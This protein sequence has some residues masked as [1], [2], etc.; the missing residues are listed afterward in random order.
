MSPA[1]QIVLAEQDI[2]VIPERGDRL[3][4]DQARRAREGP[5]RAL[6]QWASPDHS[7]SMAVRIFGMSYMGKLAVFICEGALG[8]R[9]ALALKS[10]APAI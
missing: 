4:V 8:R 1:D 7:V 9:R 5:L 2:R 10:A 3:V 6:S